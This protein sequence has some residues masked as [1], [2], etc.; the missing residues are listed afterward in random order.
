MVSGSN[1]GESHSM[2][3]I[4]I[5]KKG[6]LA[7]QKLRVWEGGKKIVAHSPLV[8]DGHNSFYQLS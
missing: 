3:Y 5:P 6:L 1:V 8:L 4:H 7:N 2:E